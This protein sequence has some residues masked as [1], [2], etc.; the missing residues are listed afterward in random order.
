[1]EIPQA[2]PA[3]KAIR[4]RLP[5]RRENIS[6]PFEHEGHHY[7][8]MTGRFPDGRLAEI[9]LTV[10]GKQGTPLQSNA[11][12]AAV[13]TSLCLQHGI[14]PDVIRHSITGPIAIALA[15]VEGGT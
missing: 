12:D 14:A 6:L 13:L 4:E 5:N 1:M 9:F 7:R 11:D 8:V 2:A 3:D 10:P 15:L